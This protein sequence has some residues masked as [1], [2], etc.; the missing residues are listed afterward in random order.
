MLAIGVQ[1]E[2]FLLARC[3]VS[4]TPVVGKG[5]FCLHGHHFEA[6]DSM[7]RYAFAAL[8]PTDE[9]FHKFNTVT[10]D[11]YAQ[12]SPSTGVQIY[13]Q[14]RSLILPGDYIVCESR[15]V[16]LWFNRSGNDPSVINVLEDGMM[17]SMEIERVVY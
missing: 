5:S 9:N 14:P 8:C 1:S 2:A 10:V 16:N 13:A 17:F 15:N 6:D 11:L 4:S 12:G 3:H 7:R